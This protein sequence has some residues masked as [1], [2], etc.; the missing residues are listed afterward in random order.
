MRAELRV[1]DERT[2]SQRS[3]KK[4]NEYVDNA[5]LNP[6]L[7]IMQLPA[8]VAFSMRPDRPRNPRPSQ[9]ED[10]VKGF[11]ESCSHYSASERL[12]PQVTS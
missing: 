8:I 10:G 11:A 9:K 6:L 5:I 4:V 12:C 7:F 2:L 1:I 3:L